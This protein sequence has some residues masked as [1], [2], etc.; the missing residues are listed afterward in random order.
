MQFYHASVYWLIAVTF[1][2]LESWKFQLMNN[3][4]NCRI[5]SA[6]CSSYDLMLQYSFHADKFNLNPS[7]TFFWSDM[8]CSCTDKHI[9][10]PRNTFDEY[11]KIVVQQCIT[12]GLNHVVT[13]ISCH[14]LLLNRL[15][16]LCWKSDIHVSDINRFS[17][18]IALCA[19]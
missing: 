2:S 14:T 18:I 4:T 19:T 17:Y 15:L 9:T 1:L 16:K 6:C 12:G 10:Q 13:H 7:N 3:T 11:W 8:P 5:V